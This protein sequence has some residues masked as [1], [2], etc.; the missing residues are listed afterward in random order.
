METTEFNHALTAEGYLN[1][2]DIERDYKLDL[3]LEKVELLLEQQSYEVFETE[4]I[5]AAAALFAKLA[6]K[7]SVAA[8]KVARKHQAS[9]M[10]FIQRGL[11]G[12]ALRQ[13]IYRDLRSVGVNSNTAD[14][15]AW[16]VSTVVSRVSIR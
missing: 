2:L 1:D 3:L 10:R 14:I 5:I 13:A 16:A 6:K 11:V 4:G 9:I 7:L 15:I 8:L 12:R